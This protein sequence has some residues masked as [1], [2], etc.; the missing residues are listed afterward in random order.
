MRRT[1]VKTEAKGESEPIDSDEQ[2]SIVDTYRDEYNREATL[3]R[4]AFTFMNAGGFVTVSY[5]CFAL[6]TRPPG[7]IAPLQHQQMCGASRL[8]RFASCLT[9]DTMQ[10]PIGSSKKCRTST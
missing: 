5:C 7:T 1:A 4:L 8:R 9:F 6:A 3:I 2:Q 10:N